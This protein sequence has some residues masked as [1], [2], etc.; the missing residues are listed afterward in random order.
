[1]QTWSYIDNAPAID[2]PVDEV[3]LQIQDAVQAEQYLT[4]YLPNVLQSAKRLHADIINHFGAGPADLSD[5]G[6]RVMLICLARVALRHGSMSEWSYDYHNEVHSLDVLEHVL[7]LAGPRPDI[8]ND[9]HGLRQLGPI[10]SLCLELFAATHDIWQT[11]SGYSVSGIGHN[12]HASAEEAMR[13]LLAA[14]LD[15][16]LHQPLFQLLRWMIYGSTFFARAME[17]EDTAVKPGALAPVVAQQVIAGNQSVG[18][19]NAKQAADLVLLAADI[20]TGNV[21]EPI[22]QYAAQSVRMCLEA[23][24]GLDLNQTDQSTS[25]SVLNFLTTNQEQYFFQQQRFYSAIARHA[26]SA[27]KTETGSLLKELISWL[28][29]R[30]AAQPGRSAELPAAAAI[31]ED[32]TTKAESLAM[33][34]AEAVLRR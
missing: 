21:A 13:I 15:G 12:E 5:A 14:G 20:D 28:R 7:M 32:F 9:Y 6:Y 34:P 1:M 11:K 4:T 3:E 19:F 31:V 2:W 23:H 29:R 17:F 10:S 24:R 16:Q 25:R 33:Q 26:L 22:M 18:E 27:A 30:Y 8:P